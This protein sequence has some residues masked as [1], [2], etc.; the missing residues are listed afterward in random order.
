LQ[1][2]VPPEGAAVLSV[3]E[4]KLWRKYNGLG[5]P[6][7]LKTSLTEY[8]QAKQSVMMLNR[9]ISLRD[10]AEILNYKVV[11]LR[12]IIPAE[13]ALEVR[14]DDGERKAYAIVNGESV[15]MSDYV[16]KNLADFIP[17]LV[18]AAPMPIIP[19]L[20]EGSGTA[21]NI[22]SSLV[23]NRVKALATR[24]LNGVSNGG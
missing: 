21:I 20:N 22:I 10:A 17:A 19:Q 11:V 24:G 13:V 14:V 7:A 15:P 2:L 8:E 16:Q 23:D 3:E 4:A 6:D 5:A 9:E 1:S 12:Q 18:K